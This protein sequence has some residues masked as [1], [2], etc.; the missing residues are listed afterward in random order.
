LDLEISLT[1]AKVN[2]DVK[3]SAGMVTGE[4]SYKIILFYNN[5]PLR[6]KRGSCSWDPLVGK[7]R[8][9]YDC[10]WI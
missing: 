3:L 2:K 4:T 8:L 1:A 10:V 9:L 5:E 7:S 6:D